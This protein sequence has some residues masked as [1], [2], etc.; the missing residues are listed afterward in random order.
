MCTGTHTQ[1]FSFFPPIFCLV[2]GFSLC[3]TNRKCREKKREKFSER[4]REGRWPP[5][6]K[7]CRHTHARARAISN[8][9]ANSSSSS[10]STHSAPPIHPIFNSCFCCILFRATHV[11]AKLAWNPPNNK[12][13]TR[14]DEKSTHLFLIILSKKDE[15][16]KKPT[17][18]CTNDAHN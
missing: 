10:F 1:L 6:S 12:C 8:R 14:I 16:R 4:R 18:T 17:L 11:C 2:V 15:Q 7:T 9:E 3:K 5:E 13:N